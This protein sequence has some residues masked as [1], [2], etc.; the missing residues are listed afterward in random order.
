MDERMTGV[1]VHVDQHNKKFLVN[2]EDI[3]RMIKPEYTVEIN[4]QSMAEVTVTFLAESLAW[5]LPN[6]TRIKH[7]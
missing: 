4:E 6:G 3:S 2:G 5:T 1:A 7:A